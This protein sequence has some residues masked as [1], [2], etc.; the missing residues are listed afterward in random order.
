MSATNSFPSGHTF[1]AFTGAEILRR[2]YGSQYP[3]LAVACYATAM[4]VGFMRIYNN[5]HWVGDVLAG[6]GL[7]MIGV[8]IVYFTFDK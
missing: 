2:E 3:W 1:M 7:G 4:L 8:S 6:A 5:R